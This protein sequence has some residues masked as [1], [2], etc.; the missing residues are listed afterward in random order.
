MT[1]LASLGHQS[2]Q[3]GTGGRSLKLLAELLTG[4]GQGVRPPFPPCPNRHEEGGWQE[5][6][7]GDESGQAT[8]AQ[9]LS[10]LRQD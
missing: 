10:S 4:P 7:V 9:G 3:S 8:H 1:L 5:E 6:S 2:V